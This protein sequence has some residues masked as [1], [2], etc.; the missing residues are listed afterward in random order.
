MKEI[1]LGIRNQD[2]E[3]YHWQKVSSSFR[4]YD[5]PTIIWLP[6]ANV[7]HPRKV[8]GALKVLEKS[9]QLTSSFFSHIPIRLT[10]AYYDGFDINEHRQHMQAETQNLSDIDSITFKPI[11]VPEYKIYCRD[12]F[13]QYFKDI[14]CDESGQK[15]PIKTVIQRMRNLT[16]VSHCYGGLIAY[17]IEQQMQAE[18][19]RLAFTN[20]E[21]HKIQKQLTIINLASRIPIGRMKSTVIHTFSLLDN[22]W[23]NGWSDENIFSFLQTNILSQ[24]K[25]AICSDLS[26]LTHS[27][28][29]L[30]SFSKN[31]IL[32]CC[33]KICYEKGMEHRAL[34][35]QNADN[36]FQDMT[37]N[38]QNV[39]SFILQFLEEKNQKINLSLS[40]FIHKWRTTEL[41][42]VFCQNG[43]R[44]MDEYRF[45]LKKC[46]IGRTSLHQC[47]REKKNAELQSLINGWTVPVNLTDKYG[48]FPLFEAVQTKNVF[49]LLQIMQKM[50]YNEILQIKNVHNQKDIIQD[51][52]GT[53]DAEM[54]IPFCQVLI[55]KNAHLARYVLQPQLRM[56]C[57]N[58][59]HQNRPMGELLSLLYDFECQQF[60]SVDIFELKSMYMLT[61]KYTDEMAKQNRNCI[62]NAVKKMMQS[63]I[64]IYQSDMLRLFITHLKKDNT[65]DEFMAV[66]LNEQKDKINVSPEKLQHML[67]RYFSCWDSQSGRLSSFLKLVLPYAYE[68]EERYLTKVYDYLFYETNSQTHQRVVERLTKRYMNIVH[69]QLMWLK[70]QARTNAD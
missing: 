54:I 29:A 13:N 6:G 16:I 3:P 19:E 55:Q 15:M 23:M 47:I 40:Q 56:Y 33:P 53:Q 48:N 57:Q 21:R 66:V 65:P 41:G 5:V 59:A 70:K 62:L 2:I 30:I 18:M 8:N 60:Q 20:A 1:H 69:Q 10:G 34:L 52:F 45:Y 4:I 67:L 51:V 28:S 42:T 44:I 7:Y 32:L 36:P 12:F 64:G 24:I 11:P 9:L 26:R 50:D 14:F 61:E 58:C 22:E 25:G 46:Q 68:R 63:G 38:A 35:G 43:M 31:E 37:P 17:E 27:N 39:Y 49:G